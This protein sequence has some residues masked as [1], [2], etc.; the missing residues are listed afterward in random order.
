MSLTIW[1]LIEAGPNLVQ[2]YAYGD[3][4]ACFGNSAN[5]G[6]SPGGEVEVKTCADI[7]L[8]CVCVSDVPLQRWIECW[9]RVRAPSPASDTK[10]GSI[11]G[12]KLT[13]LAMRGTRGK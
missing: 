12:P 6:F 1:P 2:H 3:A 8:M 10:Y 13:S 4:P 9:R 7:H 11:S 5:I